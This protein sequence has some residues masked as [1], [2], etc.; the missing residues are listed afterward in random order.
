MG[1]DR[2]GVLAAAKGGGTCKVI[3]AAQML[4]FIRM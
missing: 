4:D 3:L 1:K 2:A